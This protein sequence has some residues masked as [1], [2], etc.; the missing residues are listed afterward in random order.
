MG[1]PYDLLLRLVSHIAQMA[2]DE[3][4]Q[5]EKERNANG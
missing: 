2:E 3:Q 5:I 4:K 1:L